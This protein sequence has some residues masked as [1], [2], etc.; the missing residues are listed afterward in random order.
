LEAYDQLHGTRFD[1]EKLNVWPSEYGSP[2]LNSFITA[3]K[4]VPFQFGPS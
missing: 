1:W 3:K 4:R 2:E